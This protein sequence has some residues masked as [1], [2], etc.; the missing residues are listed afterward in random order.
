MLVMES[1]ALLLIG[2]IACFSINV[3]FDLPSANENIDNVVSLN[4]E[5]AN[6]GQI[7]LPTMHGAILE[8]NINRDDD[9]GIYA[10]LIYN[11]AFQGSISLDGWSLFWQG[12]IAASTIVPLSSA[13]P[14]QLRYALITNSTLTSDFRN[15]GF[16]GM[17]IQARN[18][19][20]RF[21]YRPLSGAY[22]ASGKLNIGFSN[23]SGQ[24]IYGSKGDFEFNLISCFSPTY[25]NRPNGA[26]IDIAQAFAD[27]K[28]GYVRLPGGRRGTWT[29]YDTKGFGLIEL[30]TFVVDIGATPVLAVYVEYSLD[31]KA[32][33]P[34]QLQPYIDEVIKELDFLTASA[35][36]NRMGALRVRL[37]R[38]QPFD[39]K[40]VGI[41][42][43]DWIDP[44]SSSYNHR[45][46]AF[47][48]AL[49]QK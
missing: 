37:D 25:K 1:T 42:N 14:V 4:I 12:S 5:N 35:S 10:E 13:L 43:E 48:N 15:S 49:S 39:I 8:T 23:S 45:W 44:A 11:R 16:Y 36:N 6:I 32:V 30:L 20:A 9:G 29:G 24:I 19:T 34:D 7:I 27:L 38:S 46:S 2:V 18:Y 33:P 47:Y 22:V 26:R 28:P 31:R 41:G 17:N 21:F 3:S 40:Y